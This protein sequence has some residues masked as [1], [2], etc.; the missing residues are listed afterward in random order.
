MSVNRRLSELQDRIRRLETEIAER[1]ELLAESRAR[2]ARYRQL[3]ESNMVGV[4]FWHADGRVLEANDVVLKLT[5]YSHE[6]LAQGKMSWLTMT[7]PEFADREEAAAR[8]LAANGVCTPFEKEYIRK[9]GRRVPILIGGAM[10]ANSAVEGVCF[11]L[12]ISERNE[13]Q[14]RLASSQQ[15]FQDFMDNIPAIAF[16][17]NGQGE[18]VYLNRRYQTVFNDGTQLLGKNDEEMFGAELATHLQKEDLAVLARGTALES[19]S[20]IPTPDGVLRT[21]LTYK[22]PVAL[23]GRDGLIGG[24]AVDISEV[25]R[26]K[27]ELERVNLDL[28]S[29]VVER[30]QA[31]EQANQELRNQIAARQLAQSEAR[32][33]ESRFHEWLEQSVVPTQVVGPDGF[34]RQVNRAWEKLW[35]GTLAD[36]EGFN[37]LEDTQAEELGIAAYLRRALAGEAVFVPETPFVPDRGLYVGQAR[38]CSGVVYPVKNESTGDVEE[39]VILHQDVTDR[40]L[41]EQRLRSEERTLRKLLE[42]HDQERKLIAYEIHDGLVQD[43]IGG[44]MLL[45]TY[46]DGRHNDRLQQAGHLLRKAINEGRR[47]INGLRPLVIDEQGIVNAIEF[48]IAEEEKRGS[49]AIRLFHRVHFD[50]L[51]PLMEGALYR[52]VQEC[53]ANARRH[54]G[55]CEVEVWLHEDDGRLR[56]IVRDYGCGFDVSQVPDDRFGLESISKRAQIFGGKCQI[57]SLAGE[58]TTI[59]V[60]IPLVTPRD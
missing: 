51:P 24:V 17:K 3:M 41:A 43:L 6:D 50:R 5:G 42:L 38:W 28:E 53:L 8:E 46:V 1:D 20:R 34:T 36:L 54:S 57:E 26:A 13:T 11:V 33:S 19:I 52:I 14:R 58:G 22:F 37:L 23:D 27:E 55:A 39:I 10:L 45:E 25:T 7:P 21:W 44:Q 2:E 9:D 40:V 56:L 16:I 60:E 35:G 18:R 49:C 4:L 47:L 59:R 32:K 48:L 30:T 31:L 12:D 15:V 29:R